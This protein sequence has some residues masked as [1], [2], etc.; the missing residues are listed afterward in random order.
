MFPL[1]AIVD[2]AIAIHHGYDPVDLARRF[3][4][5][6]ARLLQLRAK[7]APAGQFLEWAD[8]IC[9]ASRECGATV[10]INDRVDIAL[11]AGAAGVHVGQD[12]MPAA[13]VRSLAPAGFLIGVSTHTASQIA[14]AAAAPVDYL[15]TGPVFGTATKETGYAPVGLGMVRAAALAAAGRP[16]VAIGG[17]TLDNA[18]S[19]MD[20]GASSV[21]VIS[22]LLS[23]GDPAARIGQYLRV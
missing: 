22:D 13:A 1:Y 18:R 16:V 8:A 21:A 12:D 5:G 9:A 4:D 23:T 10:I 19:V 2:T 3:F 6:G 7:Q 14:A 17:I 20:A 15:A 11:M